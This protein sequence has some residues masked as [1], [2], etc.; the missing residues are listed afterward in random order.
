MRRY[1][2]IAVVGLLL[3]GPAGALV[4]TE[5]GDA[6][7][8]PDGAAQR[9]FGD[10]LI[11]TIDGELDQTAGD[12]RDAFC[13]R[14]VDPIAFLATTHPILHPDA[15]GNFDTRL[16]L[17]T[18][19]GIPVLG[20]D[21]AFNGG[22]GLSVLRVDATDGSGFLLGTPGEY[23]L[24]V[25]GGPDDPRDDDDLPLFRIEDD[26]LAVHAAD[27]L[28]GSFSDWSLGAVGSES[29]SYS[30][31]LDG[32]ETCGVVDLT[33]ATIESDQ[34]CITDGLGGF[35]G[36]S[37][38]SE[39]DG[40]SFKPALGD[41]DGDG[42]LDAVFARSLFEPNIVCLGEGSGGFTGCAAVSA[43]AFDTSGV[44]LADLDGDGHLDAV[45]AN[46]G[47]PSRACL[48]D[49]SG[50]FSACSN[51]SPSSGDATAVA[52]GDLNGDGD[53]DVVVAISSGGSEA[54]LG[55]GVGGF[56]S[57]V[58]VDVDANSTFRMA[59]GQVNGDG[60]LDVVFA[61]M[62]EA[63]RVCFGDGTGSLASCTDVGATVVSSHGV[64]L[65]DI[66]GDLATDAVFAVAGAA[67]RVCLGDGLGG[68]S[69]GAIGPDS[70]SAFDIALG[71]VDEDGHLDALFGRTHGPE[72]ICL[73]DG[74]G[75]FSCADVSADSMLVA[76]VAA[77]K[78]DLRL[79]T[80]FF[81]HFET[82]D[83]SAWSA[84]VE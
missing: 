60:L 48:G 33:L 13:I 38:V 35:S 46:S 26:P 84:V 7:S 83:K 44:D 2:R 8:Y 78:L 17:F 69:C 15:S 49:G 10:R 24:V 36:C 74:T 19:D 3:A 76:G 62:N 59:L 37:D 79:Q 82:G 66:N 45:F 28:A 25:A 1:L 47:D 12:E 27:P 31:G 50:G 54:C 29:G 43:D 67:N 5:S 72:R 11:Q 22:F 61:N 52:A 75:A 57:C 23:V 9:T 20:N 55:N 53:Q 58:S 81:D 77:G 34:A 42:S 41:L 70:E 80:I 39:D 56:S 6:P 65:G 71:H 18:A 40:Y 14:I 51:I 73:G 4:W 16:F 30:V 63:D 64:A 32:V 21:N 68:F